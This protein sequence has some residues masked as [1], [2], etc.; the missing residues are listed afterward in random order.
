MYFVDPHLRTPYVYQYNFSVQ[1]QLMSSLMLEVGYLGYSAHKLTGIVDNNPFILG[2]NTRIYNAPYG[3]DEFGYIDEFQNVGKANYNGLEVNLR[4]NFS[5]MGGWGSSFFTLGYTWS[6]ELDNSSG[7]RERNSD[8]PFYSHNQFYG[9]GD[10]DVR[11]ALVFS[12]GW[13]LPFDHLWQGGPKL[14]TS[15]WSLYPIFTIHTGFPIDIYGDLFTST[16][17]PG[18]SG[19]GDAGSVRADLVGNQVGILN[20]KAFQMLMNPNNAGS[21]SAGNYWFNPANFTVVRINALDNIASTNAALL[22][23]FTYGS[24][25][26]NGI[27]GPGFVNLDMALSKHFK[28]SER[29]DLELR[30]DAFDVFN[31]ANFQNPDTIISDSTFGQISGT[32]L[33]SPAR[34]LQLALHL[35]F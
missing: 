13:N 22:P 33:L 6:H 10:T 30:M 32:N 19:A 11:H 31:H 3:M 16:D 21:V 12:G 9:S 15:G 28:P 29:W 14:L 23:Y 35:Q 18:P 7:F 34:I 24:F 2:T 17:D 1:Q 4:R 27:R 8:V 25:P 26:R 20:P 5:N